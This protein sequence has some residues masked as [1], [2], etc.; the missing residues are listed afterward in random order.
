VA[1]HVKWQ[2]ATPLIC[3]VT[4]VSGRISRYD[5]SYLGR[6]RPRDEVNPIK[7]LE[8]RIDLIH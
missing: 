7:G 6:I 2:A 4:H 5:V 1:T 8:P 3:V